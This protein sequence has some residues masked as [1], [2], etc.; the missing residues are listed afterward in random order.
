MRRRILLVGR[1]RFRR[2]RRLEPRAG[3]RPD[4]ADRR[5]GRRSPGDG[6]R[7]ISIARSPSGVPTRSGSSPGLSRRPGDDW[8]NATGRLRAM[9]AGIAHEVRNPLGGIQ[10]YAELLENDAS[11]T[12]WQ[13]E[14]VR[15]VLHE[16]RRLGE[17][18][19]EFLAYARPQAAGAADVLIRRGSSARRSTYCPASFPRTR[20]SSR[21][22]PPPGVDPGRRRSGPAAADPPESRAKRAGGVAAGLDC[23]CRLG[24]AGTDGGPLDRGSRAGNPIRTAR[25]GLRAVLHDEGGRRGARALDRAPPGGTERRPGE[26]RASARRRVPFHAAPGDSEGGRT[27]LPRRVLVVED[28]QVLREGI[29]EA[30]REAGFDASGADGSR[31]RCASSSSN[32]PTP[33]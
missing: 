21:R 32:R 13:R 6:E 31:R 30:L 2:G 26:P 11:L 29:V 23:V 19:E 24:G 10:I 17:I 25:A 7:A 27:E 5:A 16:I 28:Q 33:S 18:V 3:A 8:P 20:R 15:K 14:R 1:H 4:A 12:G 22:P 9:V